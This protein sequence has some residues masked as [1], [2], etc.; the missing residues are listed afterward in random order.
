MERNGLSRC[1]FGKNALFW[2]I[3]ANFL[4]LLVVTNALLLLAVVYTSSRLIAI[5][6]ILLRPI[7]T[8]SL[9]A[10]VLRKVFLRFF[11]NLFL[12]WTH[13]GR[14]SALLNFFC[15]TYRIQT[16]I[17]LSHWLML[18]ALWFPKVVLWLSW[19]FLC[20]VIGNPVEVGE[21]IAMRRLRCFILLLL[22][23]KHWFLL[24]LLLDLSLSCDFCCW[25]ASHVDFAVLQN[26][27]MVCKFTRL[28][29]N[30]R[31]IVENSSW[32]FAVR[33]TF[34][35]SFL[36]LLLW[37]VATFADSR[38]HAMWLLRT[39]SYS[40]LFQFR[41]SVLILNN[42]HLALFSSQLWMICLPA[43]ELDLLPS[44]LQ[45][46][47]SGC[48]FISQFYYLLCGFAQLAFSSL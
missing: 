29:A 20:I 19:I 14:L 25:L 13:W 1:I 10:A 42:F 8:Y 15:L 44:H 5:L 28:A 26:Q 3:I 39:L 35:T 37:D 41:D 12:D 47:E 38:D 45:L 36:K 6:N 34:R 11:L 33:R 23:A 27:Q 22:L 30:F 2:L 21:C 18:A 32:Q 46:F 40:T 24:P 31:W 48:N 7:V 9:L 4:P 17:R 43:L 16:V